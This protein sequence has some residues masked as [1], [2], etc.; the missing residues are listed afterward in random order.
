LKSFDL[1]MKSDAPG[2]L[3]QNGH[4]SRIMQIARETSTIDHGR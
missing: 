3:S 1:E 2:I 4:K